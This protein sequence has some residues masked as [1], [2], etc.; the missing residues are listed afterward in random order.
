[1]FLS[2]R[3]WFCTYAIDY[4]LMIAFKKKIW[5]NMNYCLPKQI[6]SRFTARAWVAGIYSNWTRFLMLPFHA[7]FVLF[8][9]VYV[10]P[11]HS[12]C[13]KFPKS[14]FC[15]APTNL[16]LKQT[17]HH[18]LVQRYLRRTRSLNFSVCEMQKLDGSV[19]LPHGAG[20]V[21]QL[22]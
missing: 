10:V 11:I 17:Q 18:L 20:K 21:Q 15:F 16:Y 19:R 5:V 22:V 9:D 14:L 8:C 3:V 4:H 13:V 7:V 2:L 6:N 1:M 12:I